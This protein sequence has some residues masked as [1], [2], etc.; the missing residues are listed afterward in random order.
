MVV[1]VSFTVNSS[2]RDIDSVSVKIFLL[3]IQARFRR[4]E[5]EESEMSGSYD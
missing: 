5:K 3:G 4:E 1:K 2:E